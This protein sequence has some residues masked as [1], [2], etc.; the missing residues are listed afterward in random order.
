MSKK[1]LGLMV[2]LI[3]LFVPQTV[4]ANSLE[5]MMSDKKDF[6]FISVTEENELYIG[7]EN[8]VDYKDYNFEITDE[9]KEDIINY[10]TAQIPFD[11]ATFDFEK[12][13]HLINNMPE[14]GYVLAS[15]SDNE[16]LLAYSETAMLLSEYEL[17]KGFL[18]QFI[19]AKI[20]GT[21]PPKYETEEIIEKEE[22]N[23][24]DN[25]VDDLN[26]E[27][28]DLNVFIEEVKNY[29]P[30][31]GMTLVTMLATSC[32]VPFFIFI[33]FIKI[34]KALA[35]RS[36]NIKNTKYNSPKEKTYKNMDDEFFDELVKN[37]DN[38]DYAPK[39]YRKKNK[40]NTPW[41]DNDDDNPFIIK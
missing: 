29:L 3:L 34:L 1:I 35:K 20:N 15:F 10:L 7:L 19:S 14:T 8:E 26:S 27:T 16:Q 11:D 32:L 40:K 5:C 18:T 2:A 25:L 33:F 13:N 36:T 31:L 9:E 24:T 6:I 30:E 12:F 17:E 39:H 21:E 23:A 41:S 22:Y 37:S 4:F 28:E 38:P